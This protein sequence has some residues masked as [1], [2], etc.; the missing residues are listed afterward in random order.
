MQAL[1]RVGLA[2]FAHRR[3]D[4]LS[5]GQSQRVA[6]ARAIVGAP[7]VLFVEEPCA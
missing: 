3:T 1:E 4:R 2:D 5:G 6:I 7:K